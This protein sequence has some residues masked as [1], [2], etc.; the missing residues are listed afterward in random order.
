MNRTLIV[1]LVAVS[2]VAAGLLY[3]QRSQGPTAATV[4][5]PPPAL[6]GATLLEGLGHHDFPVT[7]SHPE[8]Q[9]WFNQGLMLTYGFNHDAAERSFLKATQLDPGCA[10]CWWGAS[11]V[12]GPHVNG[13]MDPASNA[14]AWARLQRA[15]ELAP[16][17]SE[18]EQA[19]IRTLSARYAADP[20]ADRRPLD[21]AY[22]S[23]TARL[24]AERPDDLD[25]AVFHAEALM[26]LQ[27]WDYYDAQLRPKGRTAEIVATLESVMARNPDHAGALHL[28]V[29][30]VE[31]SSDPQRGVAAADRL[32]ELIP[33]SGHLVHMPA[34]IY[35]RVGRWHDAVVANQRAI[36]A[37]DAYLAACRGNAQGLYPLG[38][39]PHNHHFLWF[40]ASMGGASEVARGAA[41]QTAARVNLPDLMRQPGFAG[42]QHYWMT[43]WFDRVR[44]GRWDE[45]A[46]QA[47]PAP[48]LPYVTAIWHYARAMADVRQGRL[49]A[50]EQHYAPLA[51]LAR[52]PALEALTVWDRYSLALATRIA[53]RT[54]RAEIALARGQAD[55]AIESLQEA[56]GI[57]DTIPYD[58]PPGWHAPVRQTLGAVLL[59]AGQPAQAEAV[60]REE[61]RRNPGNGWSLL[62]LRDSL[63]AQ[64]RTGEARSVEAQFA[65]AWSNA[66]V[67]LAASRM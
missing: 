23:A 10:M 21:E 38:Y 27:P 12:L 61:L 30:A 5:E 40:A 19:F 43:P 20:P 48:D 42:L 6:V 62:G 45:I 16:S 11:L 60:Y 14:N 35:A 4:Q 37:D 39:V 3:G 64:E 2:A 33:G 46:G 26:D 51:A 44:F 56:V 52:D 25:A 24:V 53:E 28:Y 32:R 18:R 50:A 13:G 8:V 54:V 1:T 17:A 67:E 66:D 57:E 47:N 55:V 34:H 31:A 65:A 41:L 7:S 22:A 63:A 9:R 59:A 58:E 29:H 36:E 15:V 49:E